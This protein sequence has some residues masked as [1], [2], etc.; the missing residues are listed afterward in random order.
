MI[1]KAQVG[2]HHCWG[3]FGGAG[4]NVGL[5]VANAYLGNSF[6]VPVVTAVFRECVM[7]AYRNGLLGTSLFSRSFVMTTEEQEI[8][9]SK[10]R[11]LNV[12]RETIGLLDITAWMWEQR[13]AACG[14]HRSREAYSCLT[15]RTA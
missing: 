9:M 10:R 11:R 1:G 7:A 8:E 6:S 12:E 15:H 13:A 5:L 3:S 4:I 2:P 14:L